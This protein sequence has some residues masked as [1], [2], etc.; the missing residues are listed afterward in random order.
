VRDEDRV[1]VTVE[2]LVQC[3]LVGDHRAGVDVVAVIGKL[4]RREPTVE[5]GHR[6]VSGVGE[7]REQVA[8]AEG[9]VRKAV[10]AQR[11]RAVSPVSGTRT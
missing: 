6:P 8:V 5:R 1:V 4:G 2:R 3:H 11:Q 7:R 10:Y 9:R